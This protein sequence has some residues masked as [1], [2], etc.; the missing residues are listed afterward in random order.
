M[1]YN[2]KYNSPSLKKPGVYPPGT[3]KE[4]G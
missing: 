3:T 2:K 4:L 1:A